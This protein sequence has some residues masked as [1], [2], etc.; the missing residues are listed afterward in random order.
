[1]V[2]YFQKIRSFYLSRK[3]TPRMT[4]KKCLH[5]FISL[6]LIIN[7]LL[8]TAQD[9]HFDYSNQSS[10]NTGK[11]STFDSYY[12]NQ[13]RL[14]S[15]LQEK[16]NINYLNNPFHSS[17]ALSASRLDYFWNTR[18]VLNQWFT[19]SASH[20]TQYDNSNNIKSFDLNITSPHNYV[21]QHKYSD[22]AYA[23]NNT[24]AS[25]ALTQTYPSHA[26]VSRSFHDAVYELNPLFTAYDQN[27]KA[28]VN[29]ND[30]PEIVKLTSQ[31]T[32]QQYQLTSFKEDITFSDK[33]ALAYDINAI[34]YDPKGIINSY[35]TY[36]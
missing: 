20:I 21:V 32:P 25:Y 26:E 3:V 22:I 31:Q 27:Y 24:V 12:Q 10:F 9:D 5:V 7:P 6:S 17:P 4:F 1:M 13:Q 2:Y 19:L 30:R 33:T 16:N 14:N 8:I 15:F 29:A 23:K 36:F 11:S 28:A 35:N 34:T 18:N